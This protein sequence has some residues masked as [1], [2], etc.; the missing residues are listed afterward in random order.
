MHVRTSGIIYRT[1]SSLI[2]RIVIARPPVIVSLLTS[3]VALKP[4]SLYIYIEDEQNTL[5]QH[6][7]WLCYVAIIH[8]SYGCLCVSCV[9]FSF[10][11]YMS[12]RPSACLCSMACMV[13]ILFFFCSW[14]DKKL[15]TDVAWK[16]ILCIGRFA[17]HATLGI[18]IFS[19]AFFLIRYRYLN[20][21]SNPYIHF[22]GHDFFY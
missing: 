5:C 10:K 4:L 19:K 22:H 11:H 9:L 14:D 21:K 18:R 2:P 7:W 12:V 6:Y 13:V 3:P 20:K 16:D 1:S 17:K 8:L 15:T